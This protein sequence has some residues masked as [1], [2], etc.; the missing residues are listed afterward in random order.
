M[1]RS[2]IICPFGYCEFFLKDVN[3]VFLCLF[4]EKKGSL[5]RSTFSER[6]E[7][8]LAPGRISLFIQIGQTLLTQTDRSRRDVH[9]SK[10]LAMFYP[11][12]WCVSVSVASF[13][14][15]FISSHLNPRQA[16]LRQ[17]TQNTE[18][19]RCAISL[20]MKS[21]LPMHRNSGNF[22]QK[23]WAMRLSGQGGR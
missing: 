12:K 18:K 6:L 22:K 16:L 3:F 11:E 7:E 10:F 4:L 15:I 13:A 20:R 21:E 9:P 17:M 19:P 8:F 2:S 23:G 14:S 1:P 5:C